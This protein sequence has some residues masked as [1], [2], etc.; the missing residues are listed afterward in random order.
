MQQLVGVVWLYKWGSGCGAHLSQ[1]V[2]C[3]MSRLGGDDEPHELHLLGPG[4]HVEAIR[5]A[6]VSD[7]V[8][9]MHRKHMYAT[10][11]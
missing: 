6:A 7:T 2:N 4:I 8:F 1:G 3:I 10:K 5:R 11:G 9:L